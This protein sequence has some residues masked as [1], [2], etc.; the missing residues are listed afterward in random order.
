MSCGA[1]PRDD[2]RDLEP[3]ERVTPELPGDDLSATPTDG[4]LCIRRE[5]SGAA[6]ILGPGVSLDEAR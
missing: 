2:L 6:Y 1:D 3:G 5:G 4:R